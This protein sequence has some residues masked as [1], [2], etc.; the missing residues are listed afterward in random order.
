[1]RQLTAQKE[2]P[3]DYMRL[4]LFPLPVVI[5]AQT[6]SSL[7][8][9]IARPKYLQKSQLILQFRYDYG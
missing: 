7:T 1:M 9:A 3:D 8:N 5:I 6:S 2:D 4:K